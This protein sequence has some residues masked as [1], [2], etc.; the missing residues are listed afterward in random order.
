MAGKT[1]TG[2]DGSKRAGC[3]VRALCVLLGAFLACAIL[4]DA[5]CVSYWYWSRC[6]T[7]SSFFPLQKPGVVL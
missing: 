5:W 6:V 4:L 3:G 7:S 1:G 2:S